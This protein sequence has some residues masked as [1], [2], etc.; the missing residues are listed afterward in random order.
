MLE[1]D[2]SVT[3]DGW[4]ID[5]VTVYGVP[6]GNL[7]PDVPTNLSPA[8]NGLAWDL[9]AAVGPDPEG[10]PVVG[11]FRLYR[12]LT[13]AW[14]LMAESDDIPA[15]GGQ[16]AWTTPPLPDGD[17][18]WRA[19]A[20][21]GAVR[22]DLSP[23]YG[24]II[25]G[26]SGVG[27]TILAGPSLRVLDAAAGRVR[28]QVGQDTGGEAEIEVFDLRGARVRRLHSGWLEG[29]SRVLVW[30]GKDR[31]GRGVASGVYLVRARMAGRVL[32]DRVVLMR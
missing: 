10:S 13:G 21:D 4:Y 22:S 29:G 5:D 16:V 31:S 2:Q 24:M 7:A 14:V 20:G 1:T 19:W 6:G 26:V 25:S 8:P 3:W 15:V 23:E 28:L 18:K 12:H 27:E 30:D 32:T 17:Y 9:A 11:G